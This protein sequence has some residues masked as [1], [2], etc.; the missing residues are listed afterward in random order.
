M[1]LI[2]LPTEETIITFNTNG[3]TT[4]NSNSFTKMENVQLFLDI[5]QDMIVLPFNQN[6][7]QEI[8][9]HVKVTQ[10]PRLKK[11]N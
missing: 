1:E 3:V 10:C 5:L 8:K 2:V 9:G 7:M 11:R 6:D 4:F